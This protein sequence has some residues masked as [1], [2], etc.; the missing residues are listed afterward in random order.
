[1]RRNMITLMAV[2]LF[3]LLGGQAVWADGEGNSEKEVEDSLL[4][5][6]DFNSI[7][8]AVD[9]ML[10]DQSMSFFQAVEELIKGEDP[11]SYENVK[12]M[13]KKVVQSS[14]GTQK[15]IW[16]NILILVLASALFSNFSGL[17]N[18]GQL[19]EM[20]FYIVYLLL[21]GLL[22][23]NFT[24]LSRELE[25]TLNGILTFMRALTPAY[26]LSV[27]TAT[28]VSSAAMFYQIVLVIISL[29]EKVLIKLVL[30]GIHIYIMMS[31]VDQLSKE[32][33]MASMAELLKNV[34]SW[35]M[36]TM[37]GMVVGL[38]VTKNLIAPALDSLKR[39]TIGKTAGAIPGLG[40]VINSV[41]EMV[42]GSAV[43][44]RNCLGVAAVV[45]LFLC[46]LK[47]VLHIAVTGLSYR[48]LAAFSEPVTDERIVDT[49]NSMG[50]GCGLLL[51]ALFTTEVLFLLTIAILAGSYGGA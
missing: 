47:P 34:L 20:S 45:I 16:I 51:K 2:V 3:L 15:T 22:I 21:F 6:M 32:D 19:G 7:Q 30:P 14:W 27:A 18:D 36:N 12:K 48:F 17:F 24:I 37:L 29:V 4:D 46:A 33:M 49:L 50:E 43:L 8:A 44:V 42:I 10:E 1:M 40:N 23:K 26:Y 11:F 35:T 38:Q 41:T 9:E 39:T 5:S 13:V 31:F 25:N 28:G